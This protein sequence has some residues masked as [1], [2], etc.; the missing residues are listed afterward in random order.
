MSKLVYI[1]DFNVGGQDSAAQAVARSGYANIGFELCRR[2]VKLGHEVKVLGLGYTGQEHWENFSIIPCINTQDVAGYMNNLKFLWGI[3]AVIVALDIHYFQ[4]QLLPPARQ[5]GLKYICITPLESDPLCITWANLLREMDKV[6][7]ISQFGAD[8]AVKAGVD[9]E[10]IE[11]GIDTKAWRKR[12]TEEYDEMRK[13]L[14]FDQDDF[15]IM[16]VA[17]NQ[18][19][20]N[21]GRGF[22]IVAELKALHGVKVK[23]ILVT[24]EHSMVG[25]KL[26]DLA[27]D[28]E[29]SDK[30]RVN[31]GSDI[32]IFQSGMPFGDLYALYCAADVYLSCSKGEG[33]GLPVME[34]MSIGIPVVANKTGALPELLADGRG[35]IVEPASW[36]YDP[37]GNQKRY[38]ISIRDAIEKL[39]MVYIDRDE[40]KARATLAR[41]FMEE[42]DWDKSARQI[43][44]AVKRLVDETFQE[45]HS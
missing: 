17:D 1:S 23:H 2:L 11:I 6:F 4:E 8:E 10:H 9:A 27:F 20:K 36:V 33:L 38:D 40:A 15:V 31:L 28:I 29:I 22:Q 16:T 19:R 32:R 44:D 3:D 34:A 30:S 41:Y 35:Y 25:W 24:R 26:Y 42:K 7:F 18:E 43:D 5:L 12:T 13:M 39:L 14:G 37:F 45:Y 21:L